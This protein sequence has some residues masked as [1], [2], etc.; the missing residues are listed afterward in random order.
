[1]F[2]FALFLQ[3]STQPSLLAFHYISF[4]RSLLSFTHFVSRPICSCHSLN[5]PDDHNWQ[6]EGEKKRERNEGLTFS[7]SEHLDWPFDSL[8]L[9]SSS[10]TFCTSCMR[11]LFELNTSFVSVCPF[12][13]LSRVAVEKISCWYWCNSTH[14]HFYSFFSPLSPSVYT[15]PEWTLTQAGV[16][17]VLGPLCLIWQIRNLPFAQ[18]LFFRNLAYNLFYFISLQP[19]L[20]RANEWKENW[21][22]NLY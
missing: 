17:F 15:W 4:S 8:F 6:C 12:D 5:T 16:S 2:Y 21:E 7:P 18:L 22:R 14:V 11:T 3:P 19:E 13:S 9:V 1:M 20:D 10:L